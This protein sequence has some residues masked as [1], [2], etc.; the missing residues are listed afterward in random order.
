MSDKTTATVEE[1][2]ET[3]INMRSEGVARMPARLAERLGVAIS[4]VTATLRRMERDGLA[5]LEQRRE[6]ELTDRGEEL[7]TTLLR[8]HRLAERLLTDVLRV[9]WHE[10]HADAC[11][12][13][14]A[15][16]PR[17]EK[18]LDEALGYPE[19]CPHGNPIP[20]N[21]ALVGGAATRLSELAP[22]LRAVIEHVSEMAER[23]P[24]FMRTLNEH[25]V[26]PGQEIIVERADSFGGTIRVRVGSLSV[27]LGLP[28]AQHVWVRPLAEVGGADDDT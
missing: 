14:H 16:S 2:L 28:A 12:L 3:I 25:R 9:P 21:T 13:E 4:T 8:R 27:V 20:G 22:G 1:Y 17:V 24:E 5:R 6:V 15:V 18:Y 11:L 26:Y 7:A 10:A 19:R 23:Q